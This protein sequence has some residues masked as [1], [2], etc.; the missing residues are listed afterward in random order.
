M[1]IPGSPVNYELRAFEE[2]KLCGYNLASCTYLGYL[3]HF[4]SQLPSSSA[5][6]FLG[7]R[8]FGS[9]PPGQFLEA[10]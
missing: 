10:V 4:K 8:Y 5:L 3:N 7:R 2:G 1:F 6:G 9:T